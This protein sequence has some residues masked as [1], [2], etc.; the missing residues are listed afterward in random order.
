M[1]RKRNT[2][3]DS[4]IV[5]F[6]TAVWK[7]VVCNWITIQRKLYKCSKHFFFCFLRTSKSL[8]TKPGRIMKPNCKY[9]P[10]FFF[11][12]LL[13][14]LKIKWLEVVSFSVGVKHHVLSY[15]FPQF[16]SYEHEKYMIKIFCHF[17]SKS[18]VSCPYAL[19]HST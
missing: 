7:V 14:S 10:P 13:P 12:F 17:P 19:Q 3:Q 9:F 11:L 1:H 8:L 5:F 15:C 2:L 6:L 4:K 18:V 16:R